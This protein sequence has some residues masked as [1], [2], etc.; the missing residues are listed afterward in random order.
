MIES[1]WEHYHFLVSYLHGTY[2]QRNRLLGILELVYFS[3]GP[4]FGSGVG[5]LGLAITHM[6]LAGGL[7][8]MDEGFL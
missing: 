2:T 5:C 4:R 8:W 3:Y 6:D 7:A 1:W